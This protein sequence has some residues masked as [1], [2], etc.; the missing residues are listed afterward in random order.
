MEMS[1]DGHDYGFHSGIVRDKGLK[2]AD[3]RLF[4]QLPI[5]KLGFYVLG[6]P[7][8][9]QASN[10]A[11]MFENAPFR[12]V[13]GDTLL[14]NHGVP[15]LRLPAYSPDFRPIA[16]VFNDLKVIIRNFL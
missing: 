12:T 14:A 7:W 2:A 3:W 13:G 1:V 8:R 15:F 10:C 11:V 9:L 16:A 4:L 6:H 5:P